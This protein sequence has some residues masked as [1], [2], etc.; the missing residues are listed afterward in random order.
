[1]PEALLER[2]QPLLELRG[3]DKSFG[4]VRALSHVSFTVPA[5]MVT[6]LCGDNGAGKSVTIKIIS[7]IHTPDGGQLFWRGR[8]VTIGSPKDAAALGIATVYQDL[9]L[10]DNLDIVQNMFLGREV[11]RRAALDEGPMETAARRLAEQGY[12]VLFVSHNLNDVFDVADRIAVLRLG[13][14]VSEGPASGYDRQSVVE[15][16]T[17]GSTSRQV[18]AVRPAETAGAMGAGA[19]A[20]AAKSGEEG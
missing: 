3:I 8:P 4:P 20:A 1:M 14:L 2:G 11:T 13:H 12:G 7:G 19:A 10:C 16:M 17:T 15:L 5:G 9:A 18:A 6:A